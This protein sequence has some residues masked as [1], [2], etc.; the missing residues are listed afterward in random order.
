[1]AFAADERR[2]TDGPANPATPSFTVLLAVHRPPVF[3]PCAIESVLGQTI[4]DFELAIVC[5]GAPAETV[6]CARRYAERDPRVKVSV[7]PKGERFGEAYW[8]KVLSE[9]SSRYVAHIEDDDLWFPSHLEEMERLL[10]T[11]DFGNLLHVWA[12]PD[13]SLETLPADLTS[14]KFRQRMLDQRFNRFG[15]SVCGYRL[16]A[17]RRLPEGWTPA[18]KGVWPDL[19]MWRKFLRQ[20]DLRCDTRMAITALVLAHHLWPNASLEER[21]HESRKWF[22]RI[23]DEHERAKIVETAWRSIVDRELQAEIRLAK[24]DRVLNSALW[25]V[26]GPLRKAI[27]SVRDR[28]RP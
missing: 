12:M 9:A 17:Y 11:A 3:L 20:E 22:D 19:H 10:L 24:Y 1:M 25:R 27:M 18:P 4:G 2:R 16:D 23:L 7:F 14:P 5:D 26:I 28:V 8:H 13:G 15:F 21:A 6:E